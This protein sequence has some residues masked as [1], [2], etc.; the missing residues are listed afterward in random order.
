MARAAISEVPPSMTGSDWHIL[1]TINCTAIGGQH[2]VSETF[3]RKNTITHQTIDRITLNGTI[4]RETH[5]VWKNDEL[6]T[7]DIYIRSEKGSWKFYAPAEE[8]AVWNEMSRWW[9]KEGINVNEKL[10]CTIRSG[11]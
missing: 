7:E 10:P 5:R 6:L 2:L 11:D 9:K 1:E 3:T 8:T 4:F